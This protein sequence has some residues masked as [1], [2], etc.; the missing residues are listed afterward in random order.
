MP[1]RKENRRAY[2]KAARKAS[3]KSHIME[4]VTEAD[5]FEYLLPSLRIEESEKGN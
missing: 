5:M 3:V 2:V 1:G 4:I